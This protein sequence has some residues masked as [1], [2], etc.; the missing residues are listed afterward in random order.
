MKPYLYIENIDDDHLLTIGDEAY[1]GRA[2]MSREVPF[3]DP[4]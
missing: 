2:E 3:C 1:P 4:I